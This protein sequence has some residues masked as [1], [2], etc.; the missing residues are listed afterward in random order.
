M[1]G[2]KPAILCYYRLCRTQTV[3]RRADNPAGVAGAFADRVKP[4]NSWRFASAVVAQDSNRRA[5]PCFGPYERGVLEKPA[6]PAAVHDRQAVLQRLHNNRWN[7]FGD[8]IEH[9]SPLV[10]AC[11]NM[12]R[13]TM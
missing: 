6:P 9:Q 1:S 5:A 13:R 2:A 10:A 4:F 3:D 12:A 7:Q 8:R 11:R